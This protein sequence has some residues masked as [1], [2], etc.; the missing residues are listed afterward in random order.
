[1]RK[2]VFILLLL[3]GFSALHAQIKGCTDPLSKN[4]NPNATVNDGSCLY[5]QASIVP[6]ATVD[7]PA[8]VSEA[9]GLVIFNDTLYTHNDD[10]DTGL[11]AIEGGSGNIVKTLSIIGT[12][13][14]DWEEL[15]QDDDH[16]YIGDF[17]NNL[18]GN[19][20]DLNIIKV[21]K[22]SLVNGNAKVEYIRFKYSDQIDYTSVKNNST[23]FDC[24]AMVISK[25]S[26]YLFT[27]QWKSKKTSI[28]ALPKVPGNYTARFVTT[29]NVNG[30]IT[31]ACYLE[32][33]KLLVLCG[34]SS[35]VS[36]FLYVLYDFKDYDFFSGNKRKVN[37][38]EMSFHQI[39][40]IATENGIDYY[41]INEKLSQKP[42][43]NVIQKLH[44][45]DLT[46]ALGRYIE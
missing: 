21:N 39:E 9:S 19:R 1:M 38:S 18:H 11:Y 6:I 30:L 28:Y 23:D 35:M 24:E 44:R 31:G 29:Y 2:Q 4:Y 42:F 22:Q 14:R 43:V 40:G 20:A 41:I 17:G 26:I 32:E 7:L 36:P 15:A 33:K 45:L 8:Q 27:K 37:L 16:L 34:Y 12:A 46:F 13:N 3:F 5:K 25:D 10:I